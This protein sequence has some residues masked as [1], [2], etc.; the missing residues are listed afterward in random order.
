MRKIIILLTFLPYFLF[1]Q[2]DLNYQ[3]T[4][5]IQFY[6]NIKNGTKFN[7]YTTK[8]GLKISNGDILTIGKAFSKK[9]KFEN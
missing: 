2:S 4:Q 6:K 3:Q 9:R 1:S 5:D 8:N 7:S